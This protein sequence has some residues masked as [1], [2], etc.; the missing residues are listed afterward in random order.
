MQCPGCNEKMVLS[1]ATTIG[2]YYNYCRNCKKE[3]CE[4]E[5][6]LKTGFNQLC[7]IIKTV[8]TESEA[9]WTATKI[10]T[11]I[12]ELD[13]STGGGLSKNTMTFSQ[14][15][16]LSNMHCLK[17]LVCSALIQEQKLSDF[18]RKVL[19]INLDYDPLIT[20]HAFE[21][22]LSW[23]ITEDQI[24]AMNKMDYYRRLDSYAY[25][26]MKRSKL[27]CERGLTV[28]AP[29]EHELR[30]GLVEFFLRHHQKKQFNVVCVIGKEVRSHIEN[31]TNQM[32]LEE[33]G[34]AFVF[35]QVEPS[36]LAL[37]AT[38]K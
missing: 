18:C 26:K 29:T 25:Q 35:F 31:I 6:E 17:T 21:S 30:H 32:S 23:D 4:I 11:G 34:C 16:R 8:R 19:V 7:G 1:Q 24:Q 15:N 13:R 20:P 5:S 2:E 37:S 14:G 12:P 33:M 10:P 9:Q 3:L 27:I 22:F 38:F 36:C 28:I